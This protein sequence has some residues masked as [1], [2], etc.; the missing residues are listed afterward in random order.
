MQH[1][2]EAAEV[3]VRAVVHARE[4]LVCVLLDLILDV[5]LTW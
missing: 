3:H 2:L 5:H 1:T 4:D